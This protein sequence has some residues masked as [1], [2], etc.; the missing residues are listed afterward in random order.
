MLKDHRKSLVLIG[1]LRFSPS[2]AR[3]LVGFRV[4]SCDLRDN[5]KQVWIVLPP[6]LKTLP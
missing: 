2:E 6:M 5:R 4:K 1:M 3:V